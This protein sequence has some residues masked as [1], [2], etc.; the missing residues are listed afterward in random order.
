M[1]ST[2]SR[3]ARV[4]AA[5]AEVGTATRTPVPKSVMRTLVSRS[6]TPLSAHAAPAA[7]NAGSTSRSATRSALRCSVI[8]LLPGPFEDL[9]D[10]RGHRVA[11]RALHLDDRLPVHGD[12]R[13]QHPVAHDAFARHALAGQRLL[14]DG[15]AP[16]DDDAVGGHARARVDDDAHAG[17]ELPRMHAPRRCV[18]RREHE[19]L[20]VVELHEAR[21]G[22]ARPGVR[23]VEHE[24]ARARGAT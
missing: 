11:A 1:T 3:A 19:R 2:P 12:A 16:L 24:I 8:G 22:R 17:G 9:D 23:A 13:R 14:V 18:G 6:T 10:A 15:E 21:D 7:P 20:A 4:I 5:S